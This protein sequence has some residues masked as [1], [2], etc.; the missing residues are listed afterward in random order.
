VEILCGY[1]DHSGLNVTLGNASPSPGSLVE[2]K[3]KDL[4]T[5]K[6][7]ELAKEGRTKRKVE[8]ADA[9]GGKGPRAWPPIQWE[10]KRL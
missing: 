3:S 10:D 1:S 7:L 4:P 2:D 9:W 6:A 5:L 8:N